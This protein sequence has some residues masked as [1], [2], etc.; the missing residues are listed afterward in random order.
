MLQSKWAIFV[1]FFLSHF[2]DTL[3]FLASLARSAIV[4]GVTPTLWSSI[5]SMSFFPFP[6]CR[7]LLRDRHR[8][9]V[10]P[11]VRLWGFCSEG[12][13]GRPVSPDHRGQ[14]DPGGA[15]LQL[16]HLQ[17]PQRAHLHQR[18]DTGLP[19]RGAAPQR[20]DTQSVWKEK[21]S[22]ATFWRW[23]HLNIEFTAQSVCVCVSVYLSTLYLMT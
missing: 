9:A 18:Q 22:G 14:P 8:G 21:L 4:C 10:R 19:G 7:W 20:W 6:R 3:W 2:K 11:D 15:H 1:F 12:G 13:E 16:Q 23:I 5:F 17:H